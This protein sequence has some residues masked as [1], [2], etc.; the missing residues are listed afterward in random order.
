MDNDFEPMAP[1]E[2]RGFGRPAVMVCGGTREAHQAV[3]AFARANGYSELPLLFPATSDLDKPLATLFDG[4]AGLLPAECRMPWAVIFSGLTRR[5]L[6][7]FID[8]FK[9][10]AGLPIPLW[11]S[12]MPGTT[13][14]TLRQLLKNYMREAQVLAAS[15]NAAP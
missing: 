14:W 11:G 10:H 15:R 1:T 7:D 12:L 9:E 5:Q 4:E 3:Q 13:S 8:R 2:Q 6:S